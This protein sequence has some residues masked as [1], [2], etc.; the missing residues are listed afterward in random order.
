MYKKS[1]RERAKKREPRARWKVKKCRRAVAVRKGRNV[2][3]SKSHIFMS[4]DYSQTSGSLR[5]QAWVWENIYIFSFPF[6]WSFFKINVY[7]TI[8][9]T[10]A[11]PRDNSMR[12]VRTRASL[13]CARISLDVRDIANEFLG[14]YWISNWW[15]QNEKKVGALKFIE[16]SVMSKYVLL[17]RR[18]IDTFLCF[19]EFKKEE[20][21][22]IDL[23]LLVFYYW[24]LAA[25]L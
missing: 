24:Y 11:R 4:P 22:W 3:S 9:F 17:L 12:I 23:A 13:L 19:T 25:H 2:E 10:R 6:F 14:I 5:G 8:A 18:Y 15:N 1:E 7:V 20:K 16:V 21:I